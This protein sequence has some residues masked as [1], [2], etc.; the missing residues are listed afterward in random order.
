MA[1]TNPK[2]LGRLQVITDTSVQRRFSHLQLAQEAIAAGVPMLQYRQKAPESPDALTVE[3]VQLTQA[4]RGTT[5]RLIINDY[6][7]LASVLGVGAHLGQEDPPPAAAL[8]HLGSSAV[9]G[10]TVHTQQELEAVAELP[11]TYIGVGPVFG[12]TSKHTGLPPLGLDGLAALCKASPHPVLAIGSIT[13]ESLPRIFDAGAHGVAILSAFCAAQSPRAAA[14][15][16]LSA[17]AAYF[18]AVGAP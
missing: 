9:L 5:T 10:A 12:T 3:A 6:L 13:L 15:A 4:C 16:F 8:Q 7:N 2:A 11:L 14:H 17:T 18:G 1:L